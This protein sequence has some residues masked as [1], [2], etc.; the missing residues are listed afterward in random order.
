MRG[1]AILSP[2]LDFFFNRGFD[3]RAI[4]EAILGDNLVDVLLSDG[5]GLGPAFAR[6]ACPGTKNIRPRQ[7]SGKVLEI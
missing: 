7:S 3:R 5:C 2:E 6:H 4:F 1:V